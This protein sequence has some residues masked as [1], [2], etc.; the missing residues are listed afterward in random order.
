[1]YMLDDSFFWLL[2][3]NPPDSLK[4]AYFT[5]SYERPKTRTVGSYILSQVV[6]R[7]LAFG[8]YFHPQHH[9]VDQQMTYASLRDNITIHWVF[10]PLTCA[11]KKSELF[12]LVRCLR[13]KC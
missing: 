11:G 1:M 6:A 7:K 3:F 5:S 9:A 10:P 13:N 12:C 4:H 8:K 2:D